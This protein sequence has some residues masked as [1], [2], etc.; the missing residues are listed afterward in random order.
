MGANNVSGILNTT[1][2]L[3]LIILISVLPVASTLGQED[4]LIP[5]KK[6]DI[7][8]MLSAE[9]QAKTKEAAPV[10]AVY[11]VT[12]DDYLPSVKQLAK[13]Q[14]RPNVR[15]GS[16]SPNFDLPDAFYYIGGPVFLILFLRVLVIFLN[17]FEEMRKAEQRK[18][19]SE[20]HE[21]ELEQT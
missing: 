20:A 6:T 1:I 15:S 3:K 8:P 2:F 12:A 9:P 13:N 4:V 5:L 16:S 19:A 14:L 7:K 10:T 18:A 21:L 11:G 17:L